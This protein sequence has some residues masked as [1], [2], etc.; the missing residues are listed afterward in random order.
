MLLN[1]TSYPDFQLYHGDNVEIISTFAP[2]S[3][4][5]IFADPPYFLSKGKGTITIKGRPIKFDKEIGRA[6]V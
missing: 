6:H 3:I 2:C 1:N 5:M 4:D